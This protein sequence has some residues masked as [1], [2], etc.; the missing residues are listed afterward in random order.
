M[1][2]AVS[3]HCGCAGV[4]VDYAHALNWWHVQAD[5]TCLLEVCNLEA[6]P[7]G[8]HTH[9]ARGPVSSSYQVDR[10][11]G[12]SCSCNWVRLL[13]G[14]SPWAFCSSLISLPVKLC[15]PAP[16]ACRTAKAAVPDCCR[17][18][19]SSGATSQPPPGR[20]SSG[21][22]AFPGCPASTRRTKCS[23]VH[24]NFHAVLE[25][26]SGPLSA[27]HKTARR[28]GTVESTS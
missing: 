16:M 19:A 15:Q 7:D 23:R 25:A 18:R 12:A 5:H 11:F 13:R 4:H 27:A 6:K 17:L 20:S 3:C 8:R 9:Q 28:H 10:R 22:E 2:I 21:Q 24:H 1:V 26:V 14:L